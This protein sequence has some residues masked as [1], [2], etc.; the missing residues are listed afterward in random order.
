MKTAI[1]NVQ[2]GI[3]PK[4]YNPELWFLHSAYCV[5]MFYICV[6]IHQNIINGIQVTEWKLLFA[7]LKGA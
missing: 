3:A 7:M 4:L 2:R 5:M 6:K 1:C